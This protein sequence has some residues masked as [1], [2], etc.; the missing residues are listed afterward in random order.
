MTESRLMPRDPALPGLADAL[1]E[2]SMVRVLDA[3]L[4]SGRDP[5]AGCRVRS[6][7]VTRVKYRPGRSALIGYRLSVADSRTGTERDQLLAAGL[8]ETAEARARYEK[9]RAVTSGDGAVFPAVSP[10]DGLGMVV[11]AFPND[12][13]LDALPVLVDASRLRHELLPEL[14]RDRWGAHWK[15]AGLS[16]A[17]ASY[18]PEHSCTVRADLTLASSLDR[19]VRSWTIFGKTRY[20]AAGADTVKAMRSLWSSP[21]H[22]RGD[23]GLARPLAYGIEHRVLW[24]EGVEGV[25]LDTHL[26]SH[27]LD[28]GLA[29]R[30]GQALAALHGTAIHGPRSLTMPDILDGLDETVRVLGLVHPRWHARVAEVVRR[31]QVGSEMLAPA[32]PATLHGDLHGK[33]VMVGADGVCFIDLD[34]LSAGPPLA[35]LGG[36][37]AEIFYRHARKGEPARAARPLIE[38]LVQ[39]YRHHAAWPA[40]G[41]EVDWHTAA[42]LVR[43]RVHRCVTSLKAGPPGIVDELVDL[44][45]RLAPVA[46]GARVLEPATEATC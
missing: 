42:A 6:C 34:R 13:K 8:Y 31:L 36:L 14:I 40:P 1:D 19:A 11:W 32:P 5:A 43:E 24:Q 46:R 16:H 37:I 9:A 26:A 2:T 4:R 7:Q 18:F 3:L 45:E 33:N 25:T 38:A 22:A 23:F 27:A 29:R 44:A 12:R 20:D 39:S 28:Q 10:I 41:P 30:V 17:V 21:A 35:E 15:L